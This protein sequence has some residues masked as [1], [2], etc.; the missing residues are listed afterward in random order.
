MLYTLLYKIN[1]MFYKN[2]NEKLRIGCA[3]KKLMQIFYI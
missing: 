1:Q 2:A 3:N